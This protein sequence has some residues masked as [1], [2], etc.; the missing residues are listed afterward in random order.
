MSLLSRTAVDGLLSGLP[1]LGLAVATLGA[2]AR[3]LAHRRAAARVADLPD[4]LLTDIGLKRD[5]V[6]AALN[7]DWR[8]DPTYRLALSAMRGRRTQ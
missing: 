1:R 3:N 4:F 6:H 8:A 2:I 5:D 7:G